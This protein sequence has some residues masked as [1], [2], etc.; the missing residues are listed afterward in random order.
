MRDQPPNT[1]AR[2]N[3]GLERDAS[4]AAGSN[5][6][7]PVAGGAILMCPPDIASDRG[8]AG[9][10][11]LGSRAGLH[12]RTSL[13]FD[14]RLDGEFF[15]VFAGRVLRFDLAASRACGDMMSKA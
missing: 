8:A 6:W 3:K 11:R 12:G 10:R 9:K 13:P 15:P 5:R 7:H 14:G 1:R 4:G 2:Q